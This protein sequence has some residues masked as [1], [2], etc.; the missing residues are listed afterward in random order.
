MRAWVRVV[1]PQQYQ[2]FVVRKR[3]EIASAQVSVQS[4]VEQQATTP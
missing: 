4:Q 1:S 3:K 2:Q